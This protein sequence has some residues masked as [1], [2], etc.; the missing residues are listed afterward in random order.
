MSKRKR[1]LSYH[2]SYMLEC[3]MRIFCSN[4][5]TYF[6][7]INKFFCI[8]YW[9]VINVW[10]PDNANSK[11]A[12]KRATKS[13]NKEGLQGATENHYENLPCQQSHKTLYQHQHHVS[14]MSGSGPSDL[15]MYSSSASQPDDNLNFYSTNGAQVVV[16]CYA[17]TSFD[18]QNQVPSYQD[19]PQV[20]YKL[21]CCFYHLSRV[22]S[23]HIFLHVNIYQC[24]SLCQSHVL[25]HFQTLM[26]T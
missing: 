24:P 1:P 26:L 5:T 12:A 13:G 6:N 16:N 22:M 25:G 3:L 4:E 18:S 14:N 19:L 21:Y 23:C 15:R 20:D 7:L 11:K 17:N 9:L 10:T 8:V 2:V